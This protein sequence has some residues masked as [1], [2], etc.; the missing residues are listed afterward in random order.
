M[1]YGR[2]AYCPCVMIYERVGYCSYA[3]DDDRRCHRKYDSV[4]QIADH[5]YDPPLC[6]SAITLRFFCFTLDE[7]LQYKM[8]N[9]G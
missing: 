3:F 5:A 4:R 7:R 9:F 1:N 2:V 8:S 6:Q